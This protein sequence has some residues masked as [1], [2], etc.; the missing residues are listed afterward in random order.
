MTAYKQK[1]IPY[2]TMDANNKSIKHFN[3]LVLW[4]Q[5]GTNVFKEVYKAADRLSRSDWV[6]EI[7]HREGNEESEWV[8]Q[9][10]VQ[11]NRYAD[12]ERSFVVCWFALK[13]E[14]ISAFVCVQRI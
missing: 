4:K 8:S 7:F 2:V 1:T 12:S 13:L 5:D 3:A 14:P 10:M 9:E 11:Q 6:K